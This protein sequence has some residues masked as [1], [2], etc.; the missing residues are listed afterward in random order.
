MR[1]GA[2]HMNL[3]MITDPVV[4]SWGEISVLDQDWTLLET[5][6][7]DLESLIRVPATGTE[8]ARP[9][10]DCESESVRAWPASADSDDDSSTDIL[11]TRLS[12]VW[13][14]G[15]ESD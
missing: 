13:G 1:A 14:L 11:R 6:I 5:Y 2:L 10:G 3:D 9:A 8:A 7:E 4:D 12:L 15:S